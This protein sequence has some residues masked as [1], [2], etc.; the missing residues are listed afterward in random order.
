MGQ[1]DVH[2][3]DVALISLR[4][5]MHKLFSSLSH[6]LNA[7]SFTNSWLC[8]LTYLFSKFSPTE[9]AKLKLHCEISIR[10]MLCT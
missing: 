3:I 5:S 6:L 4:D 9:S 1:G 10:K 2:C 7:K 8:K